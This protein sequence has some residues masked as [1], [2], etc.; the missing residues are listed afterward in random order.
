[1]KVKTD[2]QKEFDEVIEKNSEDEYGLAI[3]NYVQSWA[4]LMELELE[5][6]S[7]LVDIAEST[8][9][10]ADI[11]G[12]TGFMYGCAVSCL[13][14]FWEHG[15]ELRQWHNKKYNITPETKGVVIPAVITIG[16]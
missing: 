12:I 8:S 4:D 13:A 10:R 9:S 1:M 16:G 11:E 3:V 6:G 5:K 2:K 7:N 14:E 15:E